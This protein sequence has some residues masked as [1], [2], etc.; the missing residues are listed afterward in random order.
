MGLGTPLTPKH[1]YNSSY[2]T[3]PDSSLRESVSASRPGPRFNLEY[4]CLMTNTVDSEISN[5][6]CQV[7]CPSNTLYNVQYLMFAQ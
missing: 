1:L 7:R 3:S 2:R 4:M 6:G 5:L